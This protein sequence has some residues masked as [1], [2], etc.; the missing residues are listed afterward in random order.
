MGIFDGGNKL[1]VKR[2]M[3]AML[4]MALLLCAAILLALSQAKAGGKGGSK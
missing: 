4:C 2:M 1:M 3:A